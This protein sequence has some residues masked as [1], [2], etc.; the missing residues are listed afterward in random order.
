MR[1]HGIEGNC[2]KNSQQALVCKTGQKVSVFLE[3]DMADVEQ[4][5]AS[6]VKPATNEQRLAKLFNVPEDVFSPDVD[7]YTAIA[8]YIVGVQPG[9]V[10][11]LQRNYVKARLAEWL[12]NGR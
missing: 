11:K 7:M 9:E 12:Y 10:T 2:C 8:A 5:I 1:S 6:M 4:R 3:I